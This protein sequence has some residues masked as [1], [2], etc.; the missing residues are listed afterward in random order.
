MRALLVVA[1][2]AVAALGAPDGRAQAQDGSIVI[3][4]ARIVTVSGPVLERGSVVVRG[5]KIVEVGASIAIPSGA[6]RIDGTGLSVYPGLIDSFNGLG[7]SEVSSIAATNDFSEI[8]ELSPQLRAF[9]AFN[10][11]SEIIRATRIN[12]ITTAVSYPSG[13]VLAGQ[14]VIANLWGWTIEEMALRPSV[15]LYFNF[16][17]GV[18]GQTFDLATFSLKRS[19]D[20]EAKKAQEKKLDEIHALLDEARVYGPAKAAH[21]RDRTLPPLEHDARLEA[22]QPVVAGA[23]PLIVQTED[24]RDI[25]RAVAFCEAERVKMVLVTGGRFGTSRI[26][27]VAAFLATKRIPVVVLSMYS[28]PQFEDDRYD[29]PQEVPGV[30]VKAGVRI[31]FGVADTAQTKDLPYQAAMAVAYGTLSKEDAIKA[32]TLWP[33]EMWGVADRVGSIEAGKV[34]NLVVTTGDIMEPM[35]DVRHVIIAGRDVPLTSRQTELYETFKNR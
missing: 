34:A 31:A 16:P 30:F 25:K 14:P 6:K 10:P 2:S 35:T 1:I 19:S 27:E 21:E 20:T 23:L 32:M 22:L 24:F 12:G 28:L 15:G 9:D 4:N 8:G 33:A 17:R 5:G 3:E 13:G 11:N 7:L 26:A 29:L 18:G